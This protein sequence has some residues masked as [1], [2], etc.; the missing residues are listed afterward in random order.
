MKKLLLRKCVEEDLKYCIDNNAFISCNDVRTNKILNEDTYW[1]S[2]LKWPHYRD[3]VCDPDK[4]QVY[5]G[6]VDES[7]I[8]IKFPKI[9][10]RDYFSRADKTPLTTPSS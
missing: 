7:G 8:R 6:E 9:S 5:T 3:H 4:G 1:I 2:S 10:P